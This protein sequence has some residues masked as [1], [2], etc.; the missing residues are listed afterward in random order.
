MYEL[1]VS[2]RILSI[3]AKSQAELSLPANVLLI[4][5]I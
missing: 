4:L 2:F 5:V 1:S 3:G